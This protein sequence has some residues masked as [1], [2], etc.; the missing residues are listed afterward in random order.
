MSQFLTDV[1]GLRFPAPNRCHCQDESPF[2]VIRVAAGKAATS[3]GF[4]TASETGHEIKL[5]VPTK[6]PLGDLTLTPEAQRIQQL[7]L[8]LEAIPKRRVP[9]LCASGLIEQTGSRGTPLMNAQRP[10]LWHSPSHF[11]AR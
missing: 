1:S 11:A 5:R 9:S 7:W 3:I 10:A 2:R 8:W 4:R 6:V